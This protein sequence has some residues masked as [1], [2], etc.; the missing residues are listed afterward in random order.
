[1]IIL[2]MITSRYK[3]L[4]QGIEFH[5]A[6][7]LQWP[8]VR[9]EHAFQNIPTATVIKLSIYQRKFSFSLFFELLLEVFFHWKKLLPHTTKLS[10]M[11]LDNMGATCFLLILLLL[12]LEYNVIVTDTDSMTQND[13]MSHYSVHQN[14]LVDSQVRLC[15]DAF[16]P[17][18]Q[19]I[20]WL[21]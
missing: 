9:S 20:R 4:Q 2:W 14:Q 15:S 5:Q 1:M 12:I 10:L 6:A 19:E 16:G 21:V 17:S 13:P 7:G 3:S 18:S 8:A 11:C